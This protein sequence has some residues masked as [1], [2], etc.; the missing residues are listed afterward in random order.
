MQQNNSEQ[1]LSMYYLFQPILGTQGVC[2]SNTFT[3]IVSV[4]ARDESL[5]SGSP[6]CNIY[7]KFHGGTFKEKFSFDS[8]MYFCFSGQSEVVCYGNTWSYKVSKAITKES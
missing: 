6:Q 7:K 1:M 8:N 2:I 5:G 4:K 3:K